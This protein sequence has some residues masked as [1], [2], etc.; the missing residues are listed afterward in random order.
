[1]GKTSDRSVTGPREYFKPAP[2]NRTNQGRQLRGACR[3]NTMDKLERNKRNA[4]A[5]YD[6]MFNQCR[7]RQM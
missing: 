5:F 6:L 1:M 3:I 2:T 4:Q 7:F